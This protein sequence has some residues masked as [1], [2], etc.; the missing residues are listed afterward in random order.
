[1][2][3]RLLPCDR[4]PAEGGKRA[5]RCLLLEFEHLQR[6]AARRPMLPLPRHVGQPGLQRRIDNGD[7]LPVLPRREEVAGNVLHSGFNLT[8]LLGITRWGGVDLEPVVPRQ[9]AVPPLDAVVGDVSKREPDHLGL[10]VVGHHRL[11]A[12][13]RFT[14]S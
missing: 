13:K 12:Q 10:E 9:L 14:E 1:M 3:L 6:L 4:R 2:E 8:F 5:Q 7:V 11:R